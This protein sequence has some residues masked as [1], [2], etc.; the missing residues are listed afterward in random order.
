MTARSLSVV[1]AAALS[2]FT[3]TLSRGDSVIDRGTGANVLGG[4]PLALAHLARLLAGQPQFPQLSAGEIVTTGTVTDAWPVAP[5]E[6]WPS[7][8]GG[9][10]LNGLQVRFEGAEHPPG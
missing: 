5:S 2:T 1:L 9:L 4:P 6:V 3:L 8:Y 10:G 7:D